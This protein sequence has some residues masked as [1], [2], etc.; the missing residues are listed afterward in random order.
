RYVSRGVL[1]GWG[2]A[3]ETFIDIRILQPRG[4]EIERTDELA[5]F[6]EERLREMP[7]VERFVTNVAPSHASIRVAFPE[8]SELT[9]IPVAS[10]EQLVQYSR[11]VVCPDDR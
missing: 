9:S 8:E 2:G 7:E 5:R 10:K 6:F 1:W 11:L 3:N 4:G